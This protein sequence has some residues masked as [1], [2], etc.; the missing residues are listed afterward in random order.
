MA[1]WTSDELRTSPAAR[2]THPGSDA[3]EPHRPLFERWRRRRKRRETPKAAVQQ[4]AAVEQEQKTPS[5]EPKKEP[6]KPKRRHPILR[7]AFRLLCL[8][9]VLLIAARLYLPTYLRDYVNR[10]LGRDPLYDGKIG[11]IEI[12]LWRGAYAINDVR[13][14]KVTGN[15]PVPLFAAKKVDLAIEWGALL[16]KHTVVGKIKMIEPQLN[17]VDSKEGDAEAQTGGGG[18][19]LQVIKDLF[20]FRINSCELA[21]GRISFRAFDT[22]PPVDMYIA[23]VDAEMTNFSNLVDELNPLNATVSMRGKVLDHAP[24]ELEMK[25]DPTSYRPTF[26]V[27]VRMIGLDVTKTNPLTR[28]Y[29]QFDFEKGWFDLVV[30]MKAREGGVEGYVKPLF[31][32]LVILSKQDFKEDNIIELFWE[33]LV[34]VTEKVFENQRRTQFGTLIPFKGDL[35]NPRTDM[36]ATLGN[37]LRNAFIR[38]YLPRLQGTA[39]DVDTLRFSPGSASDPIT[40]TP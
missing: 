4:E 6:T 1:T 9:V 25:L 20:P 34:G 35:T 22:D 27:A 11:A 10:T 28:A 36:L 24:I 8:V 33:A 13:I 16:K 37:I 5:E 32:D 14:I 19:W 39:G 38:A 2:E 15:V 30:E 40:V 18:P 26:E 7:W 21:D 29:G 31:R 3:K 17:F 12:H 23:D